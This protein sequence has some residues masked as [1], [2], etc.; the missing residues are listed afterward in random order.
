MRTGCNWYSIVWSFLGFP[1]MRI[2]QK[3]RLICT[4]HR[5][6]RVGHDLGRVTVACMLA[7]LLCAQVRG[8]DSQ[9][10]QSATSTT[11]NDVLKEVIVTATK[12]TENNQT[13]PVAITAVSGAALEANQVQTVQDLQ[14]QVPS[15]IIQQ[16][17]DDT[18]DFTVMLRGRKQNDTTLAVDPAVGLYADGIYIPRTQGLAGA[19]VD[20]NAVE[21]LRGPQGTLYGRNTTGGAITVHTNDPTNV[22]EGSI[23][24]TGGNFGTW[25][26]IGVANVPI[27]DALAARFV[28]QNGGNSAYGHDALGRELGNTDSQYYRG[29][30]RALLGDKWTL[31]FSADYGAESTGGQIAKMTGLCP[32]VDACGD[33]EG[34]ATTLETAAEHGLTNAQAIA[35]L[36]SIIN[37]KRPGEGS[38][39][40]WDNTNTGP[41]TPH[42]H[43]WRQDDALT[44]TGELPAALE[45]RS[46]TGYSHIYHNGYNLASGVPAIIIDVNTGADDSYY[47]Q[48]F[49]LLN[50]GISRLKWI[51]GVYGGY[52][53]GPR[54]YT[55]FVALPAVFG[56]APS[57]NDNKV[58]NTTLA[59]YAQVDWEFVHNWHLTLGGR[60]S[61]D[62]RR[63]DAVSSAGFISQGGVCLVPAPGWISLTQPGAVAQCPRTFKA[64][65]SKPTGAASIDYQVTP[66]TLVYAK[67]AQGYR[68]G[69]IN[70]SGAV[71]LDS[72]APFLP[73][74]NLE[75]EVGVKTEMFDHRL[76]LNFDGY[77]DKYTDL[78]V[79]T[80]FVDSTGYFGS[81]VTNAATARIWGLELETDLLVARGITLHASAA[82]TNARYLTFFD[83]ILGDRSNEPLPVPKWSASLSGDF[84]HSTALGDIQFNVEYYWQ[85]TFVLD[86]SAILLSSVTQPSYG[87]LNARLSLHLPRDLDISLWGKN[88]GNQPYY[89]QGVALD[90]SGIGSNF[91][92]PGLPRTYGVEVIKRWGKT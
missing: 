50:T 72:F 31:V 24:A 51:V 67:V 52:E 71:S 70:E 86:G 6:F 20:I 2:W 91:A 34:G 48:E 80:G 74:T 89:Q 47:S 22:L 44:I 45:F 88:I 79:T 53:N 69:G 29:K 33:L 90:A 82:N 17:Y 4:P 10:A 7:T 8:Q 11:N 64:D 66:D 57:V 49:Q 26:A 54:D 37:G 78:Q 15:L 58:V 46:L 36:N 60:Y 35:F 14:T 21:V 39:S 3:R 85:S 28:V 81:A 19:L 61:S 5:F 41:G 12:R 92:W 18:Q 75:E 62:G 84:V 43:F 13:V 40:F 27:N 63:V 42:S 16:N 55:G 76:R 73:E 59:G 77:H 9:P 1:L 25:N 83:Q 56:L 38:G 87:L 23:D 68:S 65:F 32:P 30:L